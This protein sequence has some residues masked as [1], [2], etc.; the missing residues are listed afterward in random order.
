MHSVELNDSALMDVSMT[1]KAN[2]LLK[3]T[4]SITVIVRH[5]VQRNTLLSIHHT[6]STVCTTK[7]KLVVHIMNMV[8]S[9]KLKIST[10]VYYTIII[11]YLFFILNLCKIMLLDGFRCVKLEEFNQFTK[12]C[13]KRG[14]VQF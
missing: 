12:W 8:Y 3:V 4:C 13:Q 7:E 2:F 14:S 10:N 9:C 1:L 11:F 6:T 5:H